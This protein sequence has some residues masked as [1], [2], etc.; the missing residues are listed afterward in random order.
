[1]RWLPIARSKRRS[2]LGSTFNDIAIAQRAVAAD[3]HSP[4]CGSTQ[5][6]NCG[7]RVSVN[8]L[9]DLDGTLTNPRDGIVACIKH[10]LS[11]L[12]E[13]SP[14]DLELERFIGP[15]LHE[16]FAKLLSGDGK[17]IEAAIKAYRERFSAFGLF[18]NVVYTG[19][20]QALETLGALGAELYVATSKPQV[21]AER[22]LD[23]FGLSGHFKGIFGSELSGIRSNKGELI[24]HILINAGLRPVDTV[25]VGDREHDVH[26]ARRNKVRAVGV[27]W[28]YGSREELSAAGAERLFEQPSD[29]GGLSFNNGSHRTAVGR[30]EG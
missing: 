27:L 5:P 24:G 4:A 29:L 9:F 20:P 12:G 2:Y 13:P 8:I 28:G 14:S 22:I 7:D 16:T 1:M 23:H 10:G 17:R 11:H 6:L 21:F 18:E 19:I 3:R 26:G 15:P 25:M 30:I